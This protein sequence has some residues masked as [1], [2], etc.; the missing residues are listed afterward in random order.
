[1]HLGDILRIIPDSNLSDSVKERSARIFSRLA[2]AEA[3]VHNEP[4]DHVHFHE[5]GALDAIVDVVGAAICFELLGIERF[6]CSP[7]HVGSGTVEMAHGR[8]PVPPPAV[9]GL[10]KGAPVYATEIKGE[11]VT[12]TGAAIIAAVCSDFGAMP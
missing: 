10:L 6:A 4:V 9:V 7:L 8:F 2:E 1:R 3:L 12:P 5:V 11:L